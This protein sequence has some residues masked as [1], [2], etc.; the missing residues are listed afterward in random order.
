[1]NKFSPIHV[2]YS[3]S[4]KRAIWESGGGVAMT[5]YI[6]DGSIEGSVHSAQI[7][8]TEMSKSFT[9]K[10]ITDWEHRLINTWHDLKESE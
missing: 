4:T 10:D 1:M 8:V 2:L 9:N 6:R 3:P 7:S 5:S